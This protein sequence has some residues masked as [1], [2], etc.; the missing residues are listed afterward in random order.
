MTNLFSTS[1]LL[2]LRI[3]NRLYQD[4]GIK[5]ISQYTGCQKKNTHHQK[6]EGDTFIFIEFHRKMELKVYLINPNKQS[7]PKNFVWSI[8]LTQT[9]WLQI[10]PCYELKLYHD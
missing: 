5:E 4:C 3:Q 1:S 10:E 6:L 9:N 7:D 2:K 8:F